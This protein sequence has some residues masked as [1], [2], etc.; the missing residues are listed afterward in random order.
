MERHGHA[1]RLHAR[2]A[3]KQGALCIARSPKAPLQE[4]AVT[5]LSQNK[6]RVLH[7]QMPD[8]HMSHCGNLHYDWDKNAYQ[9]ACARRPEKQDAL[10]M[11]D[12]Q[13]LH[14][15]GREHS[16]G[17]RASEDLL[18]LQVQAADPQALK[19]EVLGLEQPGRRHML[20]LEGQPSPCMQAPELEGLATR[21]M[22][23]Q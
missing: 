6:H 11:P 21:L 12:A 2:K 20:S 3:K 22:P 18:K 15:G 19:V 1:L 8:K 17:K 10:H 4:E 13:A 23:A 14:H 5:C 7:F 16:G 9:L